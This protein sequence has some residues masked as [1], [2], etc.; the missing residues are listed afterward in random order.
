MHNDMSQLNLFINIKHINNGSRMTYNF[1]SMMNIRPL[2]L[3]LPYYV[4]CL[5]VAV[6]SGSSY[7]YW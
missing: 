6:N 2:D 1:D 4:N 7:L 5:L 3:L